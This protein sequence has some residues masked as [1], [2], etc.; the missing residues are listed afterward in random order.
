[1]WEVSG[2]DGKCESR[3]SRL[4]RRA[5]GGCRGV[6]CSFSMLSVVGG[7]LVLELRA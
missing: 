4:S 1:M 5:R 6:S 7:W 2:I 3:V